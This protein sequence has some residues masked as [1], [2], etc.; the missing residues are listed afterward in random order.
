MRHAEQ[1]E[2]KL[3]EFADHSFVILLILVLVLVLD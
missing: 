1:P 2:P 3:V